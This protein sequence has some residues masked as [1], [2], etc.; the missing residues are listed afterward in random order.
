[1]KIF[2]SCVSTEFSHDSSYQDEI[3][4]AREKSSLL[5]YCTFIHVKSADLIGYL[6]AHDQVIKMAH[7]KSRK[8]FL[9]EKFNYYQFVNGLFS[10]NPVFFYLWKREQTSVFYLVRDSIADYNILIKLGLREEI[11]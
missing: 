8:N 7:L 6:V 1:M 10:L 4:Y 11:G 3:R 9:M 2:L 5:R